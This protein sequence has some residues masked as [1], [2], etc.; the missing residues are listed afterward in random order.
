MFTFLIVIIALIGLLL[1]LIVLLQSGK[2]GGL[3]GI[4]SGG[5]TQQILGARTAPDVLEKATW[6]LGGLFIV[7]CILTNFFIGG[8][9]AGEQIFDTSDLPSATQPATAPPAQDA[10]PITPAPTEENQ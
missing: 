6:V 8:P 7:L 2:G 1:T 5:A 4:A 3:A 10:V 9:E